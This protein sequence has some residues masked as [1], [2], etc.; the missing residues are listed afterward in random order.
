MLL[1][2]I[3]DYSDF[4]YVFGLETH[5]NGAKSRKNKILL[6]H[7]KNPAL[8]RYCREH[9]DW[10][11]LRIRSMAELKQM[12]LGYIRETGKNNPDLPDK[13]ILIGNTYWSAL[14]RTDHMEGLCE[15][16]DK[17]AVRYVNVKTN[18][19]YKMKSGKFFTAFIIEGGGGERRI[20]HNARGDKSCFTI[21][22]AF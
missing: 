3:R 6:Q 11:L 13:V 16:F 21:C 10:S 17:R 15:D 9:D 5:G 12:V 19:I 8:I 18:R 4:N 2:N 14:Y 22:I 20:G 1:F 7:I